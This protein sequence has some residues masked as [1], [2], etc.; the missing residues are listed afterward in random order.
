[1]SADSVFYGVIGKKEQQWIEKIANDID[2]PVCSRG[3]AE[4]LKPL[5]K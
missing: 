2:D 3:L 5:L 1:M 4:A